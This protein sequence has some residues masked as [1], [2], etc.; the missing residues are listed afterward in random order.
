MV[1]SRSLTW[2]FFFGMNIKEHVQ[3]LTSRGS[4]WQFL[5][6]IRSSNIFMRVSF[7]A[8]TNIWFATIIGHSHD[9]DDL[10]GLRG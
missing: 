4:S 9:F 2:Y 6:G 1:K 3:L 10:A 8:S 7:C 5:L